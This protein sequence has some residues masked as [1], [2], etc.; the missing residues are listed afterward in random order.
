MQYRSVPA[1]L[2]FGASAEG[3]ACFH[4]ESLQQPVSPPAT[5]GSRRPARD[6]PRARGQRAQ[7][8]E[9]VAAAR[10]SV[11]LSRWCPHTQEVAYLHSPTPHRDRARAVVGDYRHRI[12]EGLRRGPPGVDPGLIAGPPSPRQHALALHAL[13]LD[14]DNPRTGT[15]PTAY[16]NARPAPRGPPTPRAAARC[17]CASSACG[18][19]FMQHA[20]PGSRWPSFDLSS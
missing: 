9:N 4:S 11:A 19:I 10:I 15:T 17:A 16:Q 14:L 13:L 6:C 1:R 20:P 2:R 3:F 18:C 8:P 5:S 7:P 12:V